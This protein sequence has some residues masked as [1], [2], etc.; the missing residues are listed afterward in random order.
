M[1]FYNTVR[2][3]FKILYKILF[4]VEVD[5]LENLPKTGKLI[6]C[7]NHISLL[8]PPLLACFLP[9]KISFMAKKE[10][11][12][13]PIMRYCITKLGSFPVDREGNDLSAIKNSIKI[14]KKDEALGIFPQGTRVK[15]FNIES[16]KP[17]I[18]MI[19]VKSKS[20]IIPV[21]IDS[22]YK[23]FSKVNVIIGKPILLDEYF[24][25]KLN[26]DDYKSISKDIIKRIYK[27]KDEL[28]EG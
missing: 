13:N 3:T 10:L 7:S 23:I 15:E 12:K 17:G 16:V 1:S 14:L 20:P 9:R 19:G 5:G 4:R 26:V 21:Y 2:N 6:I 18:A 22:N 25:T 24:G 28:M 11:F 27:L 8:D